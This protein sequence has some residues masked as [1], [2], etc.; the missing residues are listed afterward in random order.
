MT[1]TSPSTEMPNSD[2]AAAAKALGST[3]PAVTAFELKLPPYWPGDP[4]LWF[5]QVEAQFLTRAITRQE[6]KFAHVI[7]SLQP[8]VAQEVRDFIIAPPAKD[9][10]DKLKTELVKRTGVSKQK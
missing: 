10:Y 1:T 5:A 8:D 7:S 2:T 6:T 9:R 3:G 4:A